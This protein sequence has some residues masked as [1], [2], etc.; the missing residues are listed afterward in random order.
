MRLFLYLLLCFTSLSAH[1]TGLSYFEIKEDEKKNIEIVY[2]KPLEDT[3]AEDIY[4]RFPLK[5]IQTT[6]N[7]QSIQDG[8]II[9]EYSMR[10]ASD[11]LANARIWV[12]GLVSSDRGVLLRY[13]KDSL[14]QKALLRS[15]TPF[16]I[17][18]HKTSSFDLIIEYVNLGIVHIL[19]GYDHLLFVLALMVLSLNYKTLFYSVTAFTL[20]HS[21]TLACGIFGVVNIGVSYIEAMI[22]LSIVFLARELVIDKETSFTR[23][24]PAVVTFIF[25]LLHGFGFSSVLSDIGLPQD[26]IALSLF[27]FNLGIE[28]GQ[29]AFI[30]CA[31]AVLL[32]LKKYIY[33][34][35][36][37]IKKTLAYF[38][39]G[40]SSFW[41][42][43]RV[44]SF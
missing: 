35:T 34:H 9:H 23:Q 29:I 8:F 44:L 5:C 13:E 18:D 6:K 1:Q 31:G 33:G 30:L 19:S 12:E 39:G 24:N 32:V 37:I 41:L 7:R 15:T 3:Q 43:E 4:I 22:A 14:V 42:I 20:S 25:G 21:I 17:I 26:E 10:C 36:A 28:L 2:K 40:L 16:I 11:G 38:I 27:S